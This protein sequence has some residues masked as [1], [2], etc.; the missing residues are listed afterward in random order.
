MEVPALDLHGKPPPAMARRD[1]DSILGTDHDWLA[2]DRAGFVAGFWSAG[3]RLIPE[4]IHDV[5]DA[6]WD[7]VQEIL[8]LPTDV[9]TPGDELAARGVF[10]FDSSFFDDPYRVMAAPVRPRR[11]DELPA[12][13]AEVARAVRFME[14]T[15][16]ELAQFPEEILER[17]LAPRTA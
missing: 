2:C 11:L 6:H 16:L 1:P 9:H 4:A 15:F 7:A 14:L 17:Y 12:T 13:V 5:L 8:K 10:V 3:G